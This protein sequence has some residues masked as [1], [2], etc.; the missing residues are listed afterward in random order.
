[1]YV[2]FMYP[3]K[4]GL[5]FVFNGLGTRYMNY[6]MCVPPLCVRIVGSFGPIVYDI[7][8]LPIC[9]IVFGVR[10]CIGAA[11]RLY[12]GNEYDEVYFLACKGLRG[13]PC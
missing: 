9:I 8:R 11:T 3:V 5:V 2:P 4:P 1:M 12:D 10:A 6:Y 13:D 7:L